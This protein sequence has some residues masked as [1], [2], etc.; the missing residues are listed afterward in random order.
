[1][2]GKNYLGI[3]DYIGKTK[4][5]PVAKEKCLQKLRFWPIWF[6]AVAGTLIFSL[7]IGFYYA[8]RNKTKEEMLMGGRNMRTLPI[9]LVSKNLNYLNYGEKLKTRTKIGYRH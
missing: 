4:I 2:F 5:T 6:L 3:V 7:Y 8:S 1:M 9:A